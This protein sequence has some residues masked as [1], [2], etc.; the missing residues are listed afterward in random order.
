MPVPTHQPM[1]VSA[2]G[3]LATTLFFIDTFMPVGIAGYVSYVLVV[4]M[5]FL[6]SHPSAPLLTAI[7]CTTMIYGSMAFLPVGSEWG[8]IIVNRSLA[9]LAVWAT[10]LLG[11]RMTQEIRTLTTT[12]TRLQNDLTAHQQ[13]EQRQGLHQDILKKILEGKQSQSDLLMELCRQVEQSIPSAIC[14]ISVLNEGTETFRVG[15][16]PGSEDS[17]Q[18]V[19]NESDPDEFACLSIPIVGEDHRVMGNFEISHLRGRHLTPQD[20]KLLE[21]ASSLAGIA[22]HHTN[23]MESLSE[24][25]KRY[26][27]LYESA[28]LAYF[29]IHMDGRIKSANASARELLG[30]SQEELKD[31]PVVDLY[32]LTK[33]GRE[34]AQQLQLQIQA[35]KEIEAEELEMRRAD[36]THIWVSLTV[37]LIR[38]RHG[39]L[40]ERRALVHDITARKKSD[41][42]LLLTKFAMDH[43]GDGILMAGPDKHILYANEAATHSLGYG[44]EQ[45]IG[46]SIADISPTHAT[47]NFTKKLAYLQQEESLQYESRHRTLQGKEFPVELTLSLLEHQGNQYTCAIVRDITERKKGEELLATQKAILEMI[48]TKKLLPEILSSICLMVEHHAQHMYCS[49]HLLEENILRNGAAPSLPKTYTRKIDGVAIGPCA[50]SCGTAAYR[51]ESVIVSDIATDPLWERGR[52]LALR[53]GLQACWSTP[54][55]SSTGSVLGTFAMYDEEPRTPNSESF[56][57]IEIATSLASI[58]LEQQRAVT[59]LQKSEERYRDLYESAPLAYITTHMDGRIKSANDGAVELLGYSL[60]E[61]TDRPVVDLYAPTKYGRERA[62]H[63]QLHNHKRNK[64][65]QEELEMQRAD[66][67]YIWVSLTVRLILDENGTPIERRKIVKNITKRKRI[68]QL[69]KLQQTALELTVTG[70]PL[71][72]ILDTLC[73]QV[74]LMMPNSICSILIL[75]PSTQCLKFQ[76]GP[77][78]PPDLAAALDGMIPGPCA[79]S[80]GTA[81]FRGEPVYVT[82]TSTDPLWAN[83]QDAAKRFN[84][85]ACWS[86]PIYTEGRQV[87]GSFAISSS[88]PHSPNP[89]EIQLLETVSFL[90]GIAIRSR[91]REQALTYSELRYRTLYEDNPSMYF[92]VSLE[93]TVLSVNEFGASQLG[94]TVGEL[95]Q[96]PVWMLFLE[97]DHA[98]VE[99]NLE[100][101]LKNPQELAHWEFR[102]I[103]KDRKVIWVQETVRV[104]KNLDKQSVYLIVCEDI[105]QKKQ[106]EEKQQELNMALSNA[107]PGIAQVNPKGIYLEVN[108]SYADMLR[109]DSH[110]LIGSSWEPT[111]YSDDQPSARAAYQ[112]MLQTGKGEFEAKAIRKDGS[113]FYKHVLMVK[114]VDKKGELIGHHCFMRDITERKL[115]EEALR[116]SEARLQGILDNSSAVMYVKDLQGH[117]ILINREY[118]RIYNLDREKVKGKTDFDLFPSEIAKAFTENDQKVLDHGD[119]LE[120]EEVAPQKDGLHTYLSNKFPL[121]NA[122]GTPYAICGISTDITHRTQAESQLREAYEQTRELSARLEAAE[123]SERKRISRELHDEF[124][125][126]LTALK[127]DLSWVQRRLSEQPSLIPNDSIQTKTQSM[128]NLTD[129]LIQTVRRI[130]TSLRPTILDDLGLVPALEWHAND[131]Q[132]RTGIDCSFSTEFDTTTLSLEGDRATAL[133]RITQELFTN[134][135]RHAEA[136]Q[137]Q[138]TLQEENGFLS[139][140]VQDNGQGLPGRQKTQTPSLGLRGIRERAASFGGDFHI[141]GKSDGGTQATVRIP[142][143]QPQQSE[144]TR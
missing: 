13:V 123:E 29:S 141:H 105:T 125:Q 9:V 117:Y 132:T 129:Q 121:R 34:K 94:Y 41:E 112:L 64:V 110:E 39:T 142:I 114:K 37:R 65:E 10:A 120:W 97:E 139:L 92:T 43:A 46:K 59:A 55:L 15:C 54:I 135:L 47:Q 4:L 73:T 91:E 118:E 33:D 6:L 49:V 140:S 116:E 77:S 144:R 79:G 32:A 23:T 40:I 67:T 19:L 25:E 42:Q 71:S 58:A 89:T 88:Q 137:V 103:R 60:D 109:Y 72:D 83:L 82:D 12:Q 134:I 35:G 7:V 102:K 36:G 18:Q 87:L 101:C 57:L 98:L 11:S 21:T 86:Y 5:S 69:Q 136:S 75:A 63:I 126:M 1:V 50:G 95:L 30:F 81:T 108:D 124:G 51:K 93:G 107:M 61:L 78:V 56:K 106:V 127:F 133:F 38:D 111:V 44:P 113:T 24:S 122:Q 115:V 128:I 104:V 131:F 31:R 66:G 3:I 22:L 130:A 62:Q 14:S 2:I 100:E 53:H 16:V 27:N 143:T 8:L 76:A 119:S 20:L 28:P 96:Q 99:K 85:G 80:C 84:I 17:A 138:V 68:E 45:L 74:E 90:A 48:S 52:H 26:R 70:A